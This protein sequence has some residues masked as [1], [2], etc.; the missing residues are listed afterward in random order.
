MEIARFAIVFCLVFSL[1]LSLATSAVA[2]SATD[3]GSECA[4][5]FVT[6]A[7]PWWVWVAAAIGV[8][9]AIWFWNVRR[10]RKK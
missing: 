6:N 10:T 5:C 1:A 8:V 7:L 2:A 4:S 9:V 3:S